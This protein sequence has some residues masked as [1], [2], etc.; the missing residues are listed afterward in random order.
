MQATEILMQ[1][2]R[3]IERLINALQAGAQALESN[4][5]IRPGFFIEAADFIR[6]FADGCHHL[7]EEGVLFKMMT[8]NGIPVE[9][10]PVGMMLHEH[11]MGRQYT[12]AMRA[13]AEKWSQGDE[14]ARRDV[15]ENALGYV[16]LLRQHIVKEENILFP[17]ADRVIP[18]IDYP[19]VLAGF[20]H[21]EHEETGEG[22]HAKYLALAE[23]LNAEM[24]KTG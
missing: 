4:T 20:E 23:K 8:S 10:G 11:E 19:A 14:S 24:L 5:P 15:L 17:M 1:E 7:K 13:A 2:H 6:G 18:S 12:S 21:V 16:A 3:V 9:G 22:I